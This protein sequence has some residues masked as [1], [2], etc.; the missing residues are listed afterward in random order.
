[1]KN[2]MQEKVMCSFEENIMK[3]VNQHGNQK[4]LG[5]VHVNLDINSYFL[6]G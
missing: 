1:M 3:N 5:V 6:V 4:T 2:N